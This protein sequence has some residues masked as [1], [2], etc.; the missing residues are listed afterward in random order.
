MFYNCLKLCYDKYK[1]KYKYLHFL[2]RSSVFLQNQTVAN[3]LSCNSFHALN[4]ENYVA[5]RV[6]S[7]ALILLLL[8]VMKCETEK[9]EINCFSW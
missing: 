2:G 5:G 3:T 1:S 8:I 6:P 4:Y 9:V 7:D